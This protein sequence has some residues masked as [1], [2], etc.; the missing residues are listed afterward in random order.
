MMGNKPDKGAI[1]PEM[2]KHQRTVSIFDLYDQVMRN[3]LG[4]QTLLK[5]AE[6]TI[7]PERNKEFNDLMLSLHNDAVNHANKVSELII[8]MGLDRRTSNLSIRRDMMD[9]RVVNRPPVQM[10]KRYEP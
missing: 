6:I 10:G 8:Q 3:A 9:R 2:L 4:M 1:D 5:G 7:D